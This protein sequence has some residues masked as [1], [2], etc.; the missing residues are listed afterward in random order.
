MHL[1]SIWWHSRHILVSRQSVIASTN[2]QWGDTTSRHALDTIAF[3]LTHNNTC[4]PHQVCHSHSK[5]Q[6]SN[7]LF[8]SLQL[9]IMDYMARKLWDNIHPTMHPLTPKAAAANHGQCPDSSALV[10]LPHTPCFAKQIAN[11]YPHLPLTNT[12]GAHSST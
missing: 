11:S 10:L 2:I 8:M 3:S 4:M 5:S 1:C 9:Y 6:V 7:A 12:S